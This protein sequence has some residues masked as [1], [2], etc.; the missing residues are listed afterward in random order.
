MSIVL[1]AKHMCEY[2]QRI[3]MLHLDVPVAYASVMLHKELG[4]RAHQLR[5]LPFREVFGR[6]LGK[7]ARLRTDSGHSLKVGSGRTAL[8][9]LPLT[10]IAGL[11][12]LSFSARTIHGSQRQ[13]LLRS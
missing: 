2:H 7:I 3:K 1:S 10:T 6:S 11:N 4:G 8:T 12:Y 9:Q 5:K 13:Q